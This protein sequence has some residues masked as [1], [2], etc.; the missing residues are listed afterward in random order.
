MRLLQLLQLTGFHLNIDSIHL[1]TK[2][3]GQGNLTGTGSEFAHSAEAEQARQNKHKQLM[4]TLYIECMIFVPG[5]ALQAYS[6]V[7]MPTHHGR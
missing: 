2:D 6:H 1:E 7:R 3:D 5:N 4:G